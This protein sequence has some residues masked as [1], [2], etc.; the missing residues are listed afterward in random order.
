MTQKVAWYVQTRQPFAHN[1]YTHLVKRPSKTL[2]T[3]IDSMKKRKKPLHSNVFKKCIIK[4]YQQVK[5]EKMDLSMFT[6]LNTWLYL[7]PVIVLVLYFLLSFW[8]R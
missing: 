8:R 6:D 7:S 5:E 2:G 1:Q 4:Y 3:G